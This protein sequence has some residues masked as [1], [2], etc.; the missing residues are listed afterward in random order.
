L[1]LPA[2]ACVLSFGLLAGCGKTSGPPGG[3]AVPYALY[4]LST[5]LENFRKDMGRYPT[6]Q[7]GLNALVEAPQ[8]EDAKSWRGPY[9]TRRPPLDPWGSPY[10]YLC[11]GIRNPKGFDLFS[12]G[13]DGKEGG[14]GKNQDVYFSP[15]GR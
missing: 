15:S 10:V 8:S 14:K 5:A 12:C 3:N 13:A 6:T 1:L 2:A 9:L 7:E 11:P 4:S